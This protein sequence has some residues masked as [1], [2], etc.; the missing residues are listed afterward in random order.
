[1]RFG[2]LQSIISA[3]FPNDAGNR[4]AVGLNQYHDFEHNDSLTHTR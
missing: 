2:G 3:E 1:M 4:S